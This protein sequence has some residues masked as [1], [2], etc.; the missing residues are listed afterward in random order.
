MKKLQGMEK[1]RAE[2]EKEKADQLEN[3]KKKRIEKFKRAQL[4]KEEIAEDNEEYR[5]LILAEQKE[6]LTRG[7]NKDNMTNLKRVNAGEKIVR[8]QLTIENNMKAFRKRMDLIQS[9]SILKKSPEERY[10]MYKEKKREE[11]ERKKKELEDKLAK[12]S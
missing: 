7:A 8:E 11:A 10:A 3:E 1:K 2:K 9:A 12:Y 6:I 5:Q 4:N